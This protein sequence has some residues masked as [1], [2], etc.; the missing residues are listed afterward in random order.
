MIVE[1]DAP[2]IS[3]FGVCACACAHVCAR[4]RN[5]FR[6]FFTFHGR[7]RR[8]YTPECR[9]VSWCPSTTRRYEVTHF[10]IVYETLKP[11]SGGLGVGIVNTRYTCR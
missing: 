7:D 10:D 2:S 5:A 8:S 6:D 3:P 11:S 9:V 4:A 1:H